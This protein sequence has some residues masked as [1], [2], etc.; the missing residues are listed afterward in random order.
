MMAEYKGFKHTIRLW[1]TMSVCRSVLS[2]HV[3]EPENG[4]SKKVGRPTA[5]LWRQMEFHKKS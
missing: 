3:W 2:D 5:L 1:N 4:M